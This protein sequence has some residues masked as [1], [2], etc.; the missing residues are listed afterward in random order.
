MDGIR[1]LDPNLLKSNRTKVSDYDE[2]DRILLRCIILRAELHGF[3]GTGQ[4]QEE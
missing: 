3:V 4:G 2:K 1:T